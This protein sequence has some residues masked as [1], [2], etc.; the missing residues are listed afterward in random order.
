MVQYYTPMDVVPMIRSRST[1]GSSGTSNYS[2][3]SFDNRY[4]PKRA[5]SY[6]QTAT[7]PRKR[8]VFKGTTGQRDQAVIYQKKSMPKKKKEEWIKF[9]KMV[10]AALLKHVGLKTIRFAKNYVFDITT[11]IQATQS[12]LLYSYN[13]Q[14]NLN[15][16]LARIV[17]NFGLGTN[18]RI[19][20]TNAHMDMAFTN[21][22][23]NAGRSGLT[24]IVELYRIEIRKNEPDGAYFDTL[25]DLLGT[26]AGGPTGSAV[27]YTRNSYGIT[28]WD[29]PNIGHYC[30]ITKMTEFLLPD[31]ETFTYSVRDPANHT[32]S[33][34]GIADIE[35]FGSRYTTGFFITAKMSPIGNGTVDDFYPSGYV[36]MNS[37]TVYRFKKVEDDV[38]EINTL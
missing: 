2:I 12:P 34:Q 1:S 8:P 11:N 35:G 4:M 23:S 9:N 21:Q 14:T 5:R 7:R 6:T 32:I 20:F 15:D 3:P 25:I 27:K 38:S 16:D 29:F 13:G 19:H 17:S 24:A 26:D 28:P 22:S 10:N 37:T 31:G 30:T 36:L 18:T 33:T